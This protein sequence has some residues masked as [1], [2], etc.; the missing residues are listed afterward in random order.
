MSFSYDPWLAPVGEVHRFTPL[1]EVQEALYRVRELIPADTDDLTRVTIAAE[2]KQRLV[3]KTRATAAMID[4][5][6]AKPPRPTRP[7]PARKAQAPVVELVR[8]DEPWEFSVDGAAVLDEIADIVR[9]YVVLPAPS[10]DAIALWILLAWF[11]DAANIMP[12]LAIVAATMRSGKTTLAEIVLLFAPRGLMI[13]SL[14][15]AV[16]FAPWTSSRRRW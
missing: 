15:P 11:V 14:T 10:A 12:M 1:H 9:R 3:G 5:A 7:E 4:A 16:V 8:D 2:L 13:S 6:L